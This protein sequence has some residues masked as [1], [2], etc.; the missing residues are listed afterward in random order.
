M[1]KKLRPNDNYSTRMFK[2]FT[3]LSYKKTTKKKKPKTKTLGSLL[4]PASN[5]FSLK[6]K[7]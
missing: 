6:I 3:S 7:K 1:A 2:I 5:N 4:G